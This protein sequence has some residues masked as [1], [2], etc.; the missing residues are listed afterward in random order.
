MLR[1]KFSSTFLQRTAGI[2]ESPRNQAVQSIQALTV[3]FASMKFMWKPLI[4]MDEVALIHAVV[5][6]R[7]VCMLC[8][9]PF[10]AA[11]VIILYLTNTH[12]FE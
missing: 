2:V 9:Y 1:N 3:R 7:T 6:S 4:H 12:I 5:S 8:I 11:R 10:S